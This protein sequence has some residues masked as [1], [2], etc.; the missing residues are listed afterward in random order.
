MPYWPTPISRCLSASNQTGFICGKQLANG[1]HCYG[2]LSRRLAV[3]HA[4]FKKVNHRTTILCTPT[5]S[6]GRRIHILRPHDHAYLVALSNLLWMSQFCGEPSFNF[7]RSLTASLASY[8][9]T[10]LDFILCFQTRIILSLKH[11]YAFVDYLG[12]HSR[13]PYFG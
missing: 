10:V 5:G 2:S 9:K 7:P 6:L 12:G 4:E 11:C 1:S 8:R 13:Q 3:P